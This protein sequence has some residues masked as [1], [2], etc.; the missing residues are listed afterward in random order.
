MNGKTKEVETPGAYY[1]DY[2]SKKHRHDRMNCAFD[3]AAGNIRYFDNSE[4]RMYVTSDG[5]R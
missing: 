2:T 3:R 1:Y 5:N 4:C